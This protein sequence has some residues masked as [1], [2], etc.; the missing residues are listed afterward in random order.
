MTQAIGSSL[1]A[2]VNRSRVKRMLYIIYSGEQ[3]PARINEIGDINDFMEDFSD[4]ILLLWGHYPDDT[5][6]DEIKV[7]IVATGFD[8][9]E[10]KS[11]SA[12]TD[13]H[14]ELYNKYYATPSSA[15]KEEATQTTFDLTEQEEEEPD[16]ATEDTEATAPGRFQQMLGSLRDMIETWIENN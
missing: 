1:V 10:N 2:N 6:T 5:L 15:K 4:D 7:A 8:E 14:A 16:T 9:D 12:S 11:S 3:N 13:V